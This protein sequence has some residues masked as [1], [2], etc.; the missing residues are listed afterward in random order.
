MR[1][2]QAPVERVQR[3]VQSYE[4][5][6]NNLVKRDR[7]N[8]RG[9]LIDD[10]RNQVGSFDAKIAGTLGS[11]DPLLRQAALDLQSSSD[12]IRRLATGLETRSW[13]RVLRDHHEARR[14]MHRAEWVLIIV[15][16]ITFVVSLLVSFILPRQVVKPLVDLKGAVDHA[17][18]GNY[19]VEFDVAGQGE[20]VQLAQSVNDLIA[21][22]KEKKIGPDMRSKGRVS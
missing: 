10:L 6:L 2:G 9:R 15:S 17:A 7:R 8:S 12:Q 1:P 20:I 4:S 22:V 19:E 21:H 16:S 11:E 18:A 14:L 3:V 13:D 5:E